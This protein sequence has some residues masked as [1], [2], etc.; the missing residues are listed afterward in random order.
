[1]TAPSA[2]IRQLVD[3]VPAGDL[4]AGRVAVP[5]DLHQELASDRLE[6]PLDPASVRRPGRPCLRFWP[7]GGQVAG[8]AASQARRASSAP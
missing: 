1:M 3:L 8:L 5:G 2:L 4:V 7:L 6:H